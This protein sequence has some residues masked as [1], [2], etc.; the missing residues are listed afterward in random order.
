MQEFAQR[1]RQLLSRL[2]DDDIAV[3]AS[4]PE[5]LRNGDAHYRYRQD[6]DFYYLTGFAEPEAVAV[7]AP[8]CDDGEFILFCRERDREQE[9][10]TGKRAGT[11]GAV[12][13]CGADKAYPIDELSK[14]M[15]SLLKGRQRL[16]YPYGQQA[17]FDQQVMHW[18]QALR[19]QIRKGVKAPN[20]LVDL[21]DFI[22]S[23]RLLKSDEEIALMRKAACLSAEAHV[24]AMLASRHAQY[25]YELEAELLYEFTRQGCRAPAYDSIV[26]SGANACIL[27]YTENQAALREGDLILIDAGGEYQHYAADITRTFPKSGTFSA[28]QRQLYNIVLH[29]QLQAIAVAKPGESWVAMQTEIVKALTAGLCE[30]GILNGN[31]DQLIEDQAYKPF[32]MHNSGHW[33]GLDVHDAGTYKEHGQWR[34]LQA[35]M[36]LTIEPG[37]YI[38]PDN[39]DVDARWRGIGIRVEDDVLITQAGPEILSADAPKTID[40]IESLFK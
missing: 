13:E 37:L 7:L 17:E 9:I 8:G 34:T 24:R 33:L 32:Y 12:T 10:W 1:R 30:L 25:E 14:I 28:E 15:P 19:A 38:A 11:D 31:V 3:I 27:H 36:V 18:L 21:A 6:S 22:H 26:A 4:A 39:H 35:G 40:D 2:A 16:L 23:A 29:A 5:V 20:T